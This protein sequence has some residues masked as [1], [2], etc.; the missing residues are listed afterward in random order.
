MKNLKPI[1]LFLY[2]IPF[3]TFSPL[4][5][6]AQR[7]KEVRAYL[8]SAI[9]SKDPIEI[10]E[11]HYRMAKVEH[12][13]LNILES[14][15]NLYKSIRILQNIGPSYELGRNY[16]WL[17]LNANVS[18]D[19]DQQLKYF[20]KAL[21]IHELANSN[22]GRMI[23][24]SILSAS[25]DSG[26]FVHTNTKSPIIDHKKAFEFNEKSIF[27][28]KK[29]NEKE[30]LQGLINNRKR[31]S[32]LLNGKGNKHFV[33]INSQIISSQPEK[34]DM[35]SNQLDY[36][37]YLLNSNKTEEALHWIK[38]CE[39]PI[40]RLYKDNYTILKFLSKAYADYYEKTGNYQKSLDY[41][42]KYNDYHTK[43]LFEDREGAIS[44]LHIL[45]ETEKKEADLK[46]TRQVLWISGSLLMLSITLILVLYRLNKKNKAIS[47]RNA[48]LVKEQNHRV[49][50]NLQIVSSLLNMQANMLNDEKASSAME[51]A[52]LRIASMVHIHRQLYE[53]DSIN[54]IDMP[55]FLSDLTTDILQTYDLSHTTT[56]FEFENVKLE[57]DKAILV[58]LLVNELVSNSCK[59]AFKDHPEPSLDISLN[60]AGFKELV[61]TVK[62]NGT[63]T[64]ENLEQN[65]NSFGSKLIRLMVSQLNGT[66]SFTYLHGVLFTIQF[67]A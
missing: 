23:C 13:K 58:G 7:E 40:N 43:V 57:A 61:L 34:I 56:N 20:E 48:L 37:S 55:I 12:K 31:L 38:K 8:D 39:E 21:E 29:L 14:N 59:H 54:K 9:A 22:R 53:N 17:G 45:H 26:G 62:D 44:G 27:Y 42:K 2:I 67:K 4:R 18:L 50:N 49:K 30:T 16:Y 60:K 24:Y 63:K 36:A 10:A 51:E 19:F 1:L 33:D 46:S 6:D 5:S 28:A 64:I 47:Y 15:R 32:D 25:Y 11:A 3:V 65:Q 66:S 41:L 52:Q 35:I